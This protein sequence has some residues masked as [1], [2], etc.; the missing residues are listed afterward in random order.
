[1]ACYQLLLSSSYWIPSKKQD[2]VKFTN[3]KNLLNFKIFNF[4]KGFTHNTPSEVA[5]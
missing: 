3:S 5:W 4:E 2:K 1:M